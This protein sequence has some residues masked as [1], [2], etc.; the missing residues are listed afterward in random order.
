[1]IVI[2]QTGAIMLYSA[3]CERLFGH[4]AG[5]VLGRNVSL[6]MPSPDRER[7]GAYLQNDLK[8]GI[9]NHLARHGV[10]MDVRHTIATDIDVG[11]AILNAVSDHA[12]HLLAMGAYGHS[13]L[14]ECAFGGATRHILR[15]MT[16]PT[17]L[18]H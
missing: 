7:H 3:A 11:D 13:R 16:A 4:A 17:L 15:H 14:R 8:S 6:L 1:M 18:T 10:K 5:E 9:A 12:A 2:D